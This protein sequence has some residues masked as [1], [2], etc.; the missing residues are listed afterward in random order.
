MRVEF[1][2]LL[3][4]PE[5]HSASPLITVANQRLGDNIIDA[6]LGCAV[7][8]AEYALREGCAI[9]PPR[10][11]PPAAHKS[12]AGA[13]ATPPDEASGPPRD[14]NDEALRLAALLGLADES[15]RALL[16]GDTALVAHDIEALT[17]ARCLAVNDRSVH[18]EH[19][20]LDRLRLEPTARI[21]LGDASLH[22]LA[23]D[24]AHV[25]LLA[26]ATRVV[27]RGGRIV[28]PASATVPDGCRELARDARQWVANV[29]LAVSAPVMLQRATGMR[30]DAHPR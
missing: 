27:R 9:F 6:T 15:A 10:S 7:C 19:T 29:D 20:P 1:I 2:E 14:R 8:G 30:T 21:P 13:D 11:A 12:D 3:R 23:V 16:C 26:D 24:Q 28:A 5:P 25:A 4:C 22:G 18:G 17:G